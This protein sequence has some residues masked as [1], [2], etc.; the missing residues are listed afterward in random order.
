MQQDTLQAVQQ[1]QLA[2]DHM[3]T[4]IAAALVLLMQLGF[5]LVEAGMARSKN[6]INVAQKNITDFL[7]SVSAFYVLGFGLMFGFGLDFCQLVGLRIRIPV[8][9]INA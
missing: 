6:S 1:L 3:W 4:I 2:A 5:L 9:Q 8:K 7:V